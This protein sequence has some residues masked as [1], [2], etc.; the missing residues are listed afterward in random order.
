MEQLIYSENFHESGEYKKFF[1]FDSFVDWYLLAE[2]SKNYDANFYNSVFMNYD[3][4]RQKLFMGPAWDHDIGFG[5][6]AKSSTSVS[7][8]YGSLLSNSAWFQMFK[9]Y[10]KDANSTCKRL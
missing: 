2:Y 10:D 1:D 7:M 3:Y 9:F 8:S 6:T 5:N 4:G